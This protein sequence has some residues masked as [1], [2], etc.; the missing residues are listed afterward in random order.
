MLLGLGLSLESEIPLTASGG[1]GGG[2]VPISLTAATNLAA[3][4]AVSVNASGQAVQ[5]WGP[6]PDFAS[7]TTIFSDFVSPGNNYWNYLSLGGG[8][9]IAMSSTPGGPSGGVVAI[10]TTASSITLGTFLSDAT[11]ANVVASV[12]GTDPGGLV[13]AS[14]AALS[15]SSFVITYADPGNSFFQTFKVGTISAG[16]TSMGAAAAVAQAGDLVG[17][18]A[19]LTS[20]LF[21]GGYDDG[22]DYWLVA[23]TV[24]GNTITLGTPVSVTTTGGH[25]PI[26]VLPLTATTFVAFYPDHANSDLITAVVGTVATRTI[27]LGTPVA[28]AAS[29]VLVG[30]DSFLWVNTFDAA[31]FLV[32]WRVTATA[33]AIAAG[34]ISGTTPSWGA[35]VN[36]QGVGGAT[37]A[38]TGPSY[39]A[40]LDSSHVAVALNNGTPSVQL[41]TRS[42]NTLT[43]GTLLAINYGSVSPPLP[44]AGGGAT[45]AGTATYISGFTNIVAMSSSLFMLDDGLA[46]VYEMDTSGDTSP[47]VQHPG[48]GGYQIALS[49]SSYVL[50]MFDDFPSLSV[51]ARIINSNP[52]NPTAS[53]GC[54]AAGVTAGNA[55]S[56]VTTGA[57]GG[58][59]GLTVGAQYYSNGDGAVTT[60]NT[61]HPIGVAISA[62]QLAVNP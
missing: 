41:Y 39:F 23:G 36:V 16:V 9:Y 53:I 28:L 37:G 5:T 40:I 20:S 27:T 48:T 24:S 61:G 35:I 8:N 42:S 62:T 44:L 4:T 30:S 17:A 49:G 51:K 32:S 59:T 34:S 58:F 22:T 56:I 21:I 18:V 60:A 19:S 13:N 1:G 29:S 52:V 7:L 55:A 26:A 54:V 33:N 6:A 50:A 15:T 43:P 12:A 46:S 38:A 14:V 3:G 45:P 25:V 11:F 31:H 2:D 47:F 10:S 57:C